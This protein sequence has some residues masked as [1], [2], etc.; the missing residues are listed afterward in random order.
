MGQP[1]PQRSESRGN[2]EK[3]DA[4]FPQERTGGESPR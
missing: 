1:T 2:E 3:S 4:V